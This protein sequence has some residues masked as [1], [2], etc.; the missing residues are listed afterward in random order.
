MDEINQNLSEAQ[1]SIADADI[2]E[3]MLNYTRTNILYQSSI[4]LMAQSNNFP[5]DA[6]NILANVR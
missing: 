6:L 1:S 5:Q 4:S 2:A 3:E